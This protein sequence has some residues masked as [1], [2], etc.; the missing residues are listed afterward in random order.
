MMTSCASM[1]KTQ[2]PA[3]RWWKTSYRQA[4]AF[5]QAS[6]LGCDHPCAAR[7]SWHALL[8]PPAVCAQPCVQARAVMCLYSYLAAKI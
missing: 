2:L 6:A 8:L 5:S 3:E 4:A 7:N 1:P